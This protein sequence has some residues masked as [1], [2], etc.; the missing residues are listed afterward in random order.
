MWLNSD[1]K[2]IKKVLKRINKLK[3]SKSSEDL[4]FIVLFIKKVTLMNL[5]ISIQDK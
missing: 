5:H 2:D 4:L 1:G 3:L